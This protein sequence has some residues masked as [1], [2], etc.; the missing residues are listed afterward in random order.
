MVH[1]NHIRLTTQLIQIKDQ[2]HLWSQDY[3]YPVKDILNIEDEVAKAVAPEI[4]VRL[5]SEKQ[6]ELAQSHPASPEAFDAYLQ[7]YYY[8]ERDTDKD[9]EIAA[10]Y[11]ERATQLDP[12]YALAWVGLSRARNWEANVSV[13]PAA[14]GHRLAREAV[15]R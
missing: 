12:S 6:A 3:D 1:G 10:K 7:R 15:E 14:E 4:R 13:I 2:T 11:Y 9:T 5:T 8:F